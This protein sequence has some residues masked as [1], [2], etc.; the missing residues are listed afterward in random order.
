MRSIFLHIIAGIAGLFLAD[1][2]VNGVDFAGPLFIFPSNE[3]L[4][5]DFLGTL[6][7]AGAFLGILNAI[8]KP[9]LNKITFPWRIITLNLFSLVI[10]VGMVWITDIFFTQ[11]IIRGISAMF[12]TTLITWGLSLILL[13]LIPS[14]K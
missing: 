7:F 2:Y 6:T 5:H 11:L 9:I 4:A 8:A 3:E 13:R 12:W 14:E 10:A 1:K